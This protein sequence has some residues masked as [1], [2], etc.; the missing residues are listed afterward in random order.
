MPEELKKIEGNLIEAIERCID[1]Q[2][3]VGMF[4]FGIMDVG[5]GK[6][7]RL[8]A[9]FSANLRLDWLADELEAMAKFYRL[10]AAKQEY[11]Q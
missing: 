5:D 3:P 6:A 1:E 8:P 9:L 2:K 4:F 10:E 7:A 11:C